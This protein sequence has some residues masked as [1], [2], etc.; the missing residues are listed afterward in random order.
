M[1][2]SPTGEFFILVTNKDADQLTN[3]SQEGIN[4]KICLKI[5]SNGLTITLIKIYSVF[6]S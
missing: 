4:K 6:N 2:S 3:Q 1:E 5:Q